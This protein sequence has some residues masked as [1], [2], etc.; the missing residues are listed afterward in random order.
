MKTAAK[1]F[2]WIGLVTSI[3]TLIAWSAMLG[4][5]DYA[6][7]LWIFSLIGII[8]G[9]FSIYRIGD[10]TEKRDLVATGILCLIFCNLLGGIFMLCLKDED[11]KDNR[12]NL[13]NRKNLYKKYNNPQPLFEE[14]PEDE[15]YEDEVDDTAETIKNTNVIIEKLKQLKELKDSEIITEE[16]FKKMKTDLLNKL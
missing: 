11:L 13:S 14:Y 9:G 10:V 7:V 8:V 5:P 15:E 12:N 6:I 1:V 3:I 2:V 16:E 4:G